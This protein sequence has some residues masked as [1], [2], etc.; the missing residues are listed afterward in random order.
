[1]TETVVTQHLSNQTVEVEVLA[2][3][4]ELVMHPMPVEGGKEKA[5]KAYTITHRPSGR[6]LVTGIRKKTEAAAL[7]EQSSYKAAEFGVDLSLGFDELLKS[8]A[9]MEWSN[10]LRTARSSIQV[11]KDCEL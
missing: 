2:T 5:R 10:W 6:F 9:F 3:L 4:G 8:P 11:L 1:M 7:L